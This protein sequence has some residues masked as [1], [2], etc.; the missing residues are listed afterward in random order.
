MTRRRPRRRDAPD[1]AKALAGPSRGCFAAPRPTRRISRSRESRSFREDWDD[2]DLRGGRP[3]PQ[4]VVLDWR[5]LRQLQFPASVLD[6]PTQ[7]VDSGVPGPQI[8]CR[9][10]VDELE[11]VNNWRVGRCLR[12]RLRLA[13]G[14]PTSR[15]T[16]ASQ[17]TSTKIGGGDVKMCTIITTNS[18][19]LL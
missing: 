9:L 10:T 7:P 2:Q 3:V 5:P 15:L 12:G 18:D 11:T 17:Q 1:G 13:V 6:L 19:E 4:D 16:A 8:Y 14:A